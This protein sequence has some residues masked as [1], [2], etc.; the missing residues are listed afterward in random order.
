[1]HYKEWETIYS[2]IAN[3]FNYPLEKEERSAD[4]LNKVLKDNKSETLEKLR[5]LIED[6]Q[7]IVF[8]AGPSLDI[9]LRRNK[10]S[11]SRKTI[12]V[13]DGAT[14]ALL[15]N[16]IEPDVI[17]TDFDGEIRDQ[18]NANK[19]GSI[20]VVHAHGDN[21]DKIRKYSSE[22]KN[23]IVGTI[24]IN[25]V[26]YENLFNFG[27]FT[28]GDRAVF[29]ADHFQAKDIYLVGFDFE[30]IIGD[31]SQIEKKDKIQKLK[32]LKWCKYLIEILKKKNKNIY[33]E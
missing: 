4:F 12:M 9:F 31:Y 30:S 20:L 5:H 32:K 23:N 18:L 16:H 24:Q 6:K 8:G 15:D 22:L 13:A 17:V 28:D 2:K 33:F 29:I 11:F 21:I 7:V 27:G 19:N 14:T 3:D 1:M 25:P 10:E 26:A